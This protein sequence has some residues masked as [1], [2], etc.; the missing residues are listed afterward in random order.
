M[1]I[2]RLKSV[3]KEEMLYIFGWKQGKSF[4]LPISLELAT[5]ISGIFT[6][7]LIAI[8][9]DAP[10]PFHRLAR[11]LGIDEHF[12]ILPGRADRHQR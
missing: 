10:A 9:Q 6:P 12:T 3:V 11:S 2:D 7:R 4:T 8:G 1:A 5:D